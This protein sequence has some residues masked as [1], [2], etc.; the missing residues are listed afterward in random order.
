VQAAVVT[1]GAERGGRLSLR[2][3]RVDFR[4]DK[5][6]IIEQSTRSRADREPDNWFW[7]APESGLTGHTIALDQIATIRRGTATGANAVFFLTDEQARAFPEDVL[8]P[9]IVSV[10]EFAGHELDDDAHEK[11]GQTARRWLLAIPTDYVLEG[12]LQEYLERHEPDVSTRFL[13]T[14]R[15]LW[16]A[17]T[18]LP[19]PQLLISPLSKSTFKVVINTVRAVPSNNLFGISLKNGGDPGGLAQWLRSQDG[20]AELRR[21]SRRYPGGSHK[22]EPSNVRAVRVPHRVA[23]FGR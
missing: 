8:L 6:V 13:A 18:E 9:G 14:K 12:R 22:L 7:D 19:R 16:Y 10:R 21:L 15:A 20:Q 4:G 1:V 11:L 17:I 3:A 5:A 2:L 23:R